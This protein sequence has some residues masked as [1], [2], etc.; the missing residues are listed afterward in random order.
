MIG[1]VGLQSFGCRNPAAGATK[2]T[3]SRTTQDH[4]EIRKWAESRGAVP[5]EVATTEKNGEP[6]ILRFEFPKAPNRND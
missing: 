5:A 4:D 1:A 2:M 6:G 3:L